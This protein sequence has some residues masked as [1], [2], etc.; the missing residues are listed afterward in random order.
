MPKT[1]SYG[2]SYPD[3]A[4]VGHDGE[5]KN[6]PDDGNDA[7]RIEDVSRP[8]GAENAVPIDDNGPGADEKSESDAEKSSADTNDTNAKPGNQPVGVSGKAEATVTR[9]SARKAAARKNGND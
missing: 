4:I 1:H 3:G 5:V 6:T 8:G 7:P 9:P 2:A